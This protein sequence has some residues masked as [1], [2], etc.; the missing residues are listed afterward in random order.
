MSTRVFVDT[1]ALL[2]LLNAD[3]H[4]HDAARTAWAT[5]VRPGGDLWTTNYVVLEASAL[6]QRRM[7]IAALQVL[8]DAVLPVVHVDWVDAAAHDL[9]VAAVLAARRRDLSLVECASFGAM[10]RLGIARAFAFD[11]HFGAHGFDVV[12]PSGPTS[13]QG[14]A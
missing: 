12:P 6:V 1:S 13:E 7:G 8:Y 14:G 4:Q 10:R 2:A 9:A 3:D 11:A 5:L